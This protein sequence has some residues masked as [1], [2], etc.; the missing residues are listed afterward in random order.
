L[1]VHIA[2]PSDAEKHA[3]TG[4]LYEKLAKAFMP[5]PL[6]VVLPKRDIVPLSVTG[7]LD[8]VGIRCPG[9]PV[10]R[11]LIRRAG[12]P[13]AAPSANLSGRPSPT[14]AT[15]CMDELDGRVD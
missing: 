10:A 14:T 1:I 6:T 3:V 2:R 12:V 11:E 13:I 9:H 7:G 5:G 4:E 8:S 15:H